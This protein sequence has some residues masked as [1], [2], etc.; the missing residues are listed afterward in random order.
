MF[1]ARFPISQSLS[2]TLG[3]V[4][5]QFRRPQRGDDD[6]HK[7]PFLVRHTAVLTFGGIIATVL[8]AAAGIPGPVDGLI[9][10][11]G[12]SVENPDATLK[13]ATGLAAAFL[14]VAT[15]GRYELTRMGHGLATSGQITERFVRAVEMLSS[16]SIDTRLGGIYSLERVAKDSF[17]DAQTILDVLCAFLREH[18][19]H[20][21]EPTEH[22]DVSASEVATDIQ[23][24]VTVIGRFSSYLMKGRIDLQGVD[25]SWAY[26]DGVDLTGAKLVGSNLTMANMARATL[27]KANLPGAD[28]SQAKLS[29]ANLSGSDLSEARL[30]GAGLFMADLTNANLSNSDLTRAFLRGANLSGAFLDGADLTGAELGG[31]ADLTGAYLFEADLSEANL[32]EADFTGAD[33]TD[34]NL[35][36]ATLS[37]ADLTGVKWYPDYPPTW[38]EGFVPTENAW[39]PAA[40][41]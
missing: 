16:D 33:L 10:N 6:E 12:R 4:M 20:D 23:A 36:K 22:G 11:Y 31:G 29:N 8:V 40:D 39:D 26:L 27:F 38:P 5:E 19:R 3:R 37:G 2:A 30:I 1:S 17:D 41:G 18:A 25:L 9:L 7:D 14:A 24:A 35:A 28:L 32:F 15:L 34:V 21:P 13:V